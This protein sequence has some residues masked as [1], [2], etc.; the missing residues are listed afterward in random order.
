MLVETGSTVNF[1]VS[2]SLPVVRSE[3]VQIRE[4]SDLTSGRKHYSDLTPI[5]RKASLLDHFSPVYHQSGPFCAEDCDRPPPQPSPAR[6]RFGLTEKISLQTKCLEITDLE[7]E[8]CKCKKKYRNN[9]ESFRLNV[10]LT[11]NEGSLKHYDGEEEV[12]V[13]G[14]EV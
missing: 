14:G 10:E 11:K 12:C 1:Q 3:Y 8:F 6:S 2:G 13:E 4:Y 5:F 7:Q 9:E